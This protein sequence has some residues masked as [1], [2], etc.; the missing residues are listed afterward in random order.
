M[1]FIHTRV[2]RPISK[3]KE[4]ALSKAFGEA[5]ALIPG[6]SESWLMLQFEENCHL[7]FRGEKEMPLAFVKVQVFGAASAAAYDALTSRLCALLEEHL[8]IPQDHIYISYE[9]N[10]HWGWNG[11]NF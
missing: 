9:E 6:K 8:A 3:E 4:A 11:S 10:S 5:I 7:W 2:N 1:P